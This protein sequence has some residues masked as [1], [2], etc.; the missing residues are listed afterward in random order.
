MSRTRISTP[1]RLSYRKFT[2]PDSSH[3]MPPS[4]IALSVVVA[5]LNNVFPIRV[6]RPRLTLVK[7]SRRPTA[8][9]A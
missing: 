3:L 2:I 7:A 4:T 6:E 8:K 5:A 9:N 1:Q